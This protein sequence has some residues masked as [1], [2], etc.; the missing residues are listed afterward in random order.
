MCVYV[1]FHFHH[2][3]SYLSQL[4]KLRTML[5]DEFGSDCVEMESNIDESQE[6]VFRVQ[7]PVL[8]S[9]ELHHDFFDKLH[10]VMQSQAHLTPHFTQMHFDFDSGDSL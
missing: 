5:R 1:A 6:V 3:T 2:D 9:S 8:K 4:T 7:L 10:F